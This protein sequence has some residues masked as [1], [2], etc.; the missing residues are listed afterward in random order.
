MDGPKAAVL[1]ALSGNN[2]GAPVQ[3]RAAPST[4]QP[5]QRQPDMVPMG[6]AVAA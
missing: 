5:V 1:A 6:R 2:P 4:E 3:R